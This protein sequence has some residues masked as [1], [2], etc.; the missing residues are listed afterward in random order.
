LNV[1]P[2]VFAAQHSPDRSVSLGALGLQTARYTGEGDATGA[3]AQVVMGIPDLSIT[4]RDQDER[5]LY[6]ASNGIYGFLRLPHAAN[7]QRL[8]IHDAAGRYL[9]KVL[10]HDVP[11]RDD[12]RAR[13]EQG[14]PIG[15]PAVD[16]IIKRLLMR[17]A[18]SVPLEGA[19]TAL[20]GRVVGSDGLPIPLARLRIATRVNGDDTA[21]IAFSNLHGDYFA[22]LCGERADYDLPED[23]GDDDPLAP[24]DDGD[25]GGA[26]IQTSFTRALQAV[27]L[28]DA[29]VLDEL[30]HRLAH[31]TEPLRA[32][33]PGFDEVDPAAPG[34]PFTA[35]G[36]FELHPHPPGPPADEFTIHIGQRVRW[37]VHLT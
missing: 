5:P 34:S 20:W 4:V 30:R 3:G 11:D 23:D 26:S 9:P 25:A 2:L 18:L 29:A 37:D 7:P 33:P 14:Q 10:E 17:P 31:D 13:L 22:P 1:D 28:L 19:V 21:F 27:H 12:E 16:T 15:G 32:L 8:E 6:H 24:P 36:S 35:H